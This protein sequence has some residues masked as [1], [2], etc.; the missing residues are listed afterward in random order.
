MNSGL[1]KDISGFSLHGFDF[2]GKILGKDKI[3]GDTFGYA[4][5]GSKTVF[6]L[7]DATGHGVQAGFTVAVLSKLFFEFS[8]KIKLFQ[9]LFSTINNELKER[10]KGRIFVTS[11][12]FELDSTSNKLSFI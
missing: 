6:Y 5:E 8:K 4:K 2:Y 9:D 10:L 11:I 12:F 7:G 1:S 3:V